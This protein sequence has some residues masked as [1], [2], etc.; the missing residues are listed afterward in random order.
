MVHRRTHLR[1]CVQATLAALGP[2]HYFIGREQARS[3]GYYRS[4]WYTA[5]YTDCGRTFSRPHRYGHRNHVVVKI[6]VAGASAQT[7]TA[8]PV[9][10]V[11]ATIGGVSDVGRDDAAMAVVFGPDGSLGA[12]ETA[13]DG[14]CTAPIVSAIARAQSSIKSLPL[15]RL[16][17]RSLRKWDLGR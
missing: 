8:S 11:S 9:S 6:V 2:R 12:I 4:T 15:L 13:P 5:N 3:H 14:N 16:C 17:R 7:A 1:R 10:A